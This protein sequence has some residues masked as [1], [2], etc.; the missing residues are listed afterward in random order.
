MNFK[1]L[2][3]L[4][5]L[6]LGITNGAHAV[7]IYDVKNKKQI[8]RAEFLNQLDGVDQIVVGEKHYDS[9]ILNESSSLMLDWQQRKN[10]PLTFAWEFLNVNDQA[11][12]NENFA[13]VKAG[14]LSAFDFI[15]LVFGL[16]ASEVAYVP[17]ITAALDARA[18]LLAV[19]LS[20]AEKASV[21]TGGISAL[22]PLLLPPGFALGSVQYFERFEA[23][24]GGH[25]TP[26]KLA[27]YFAAQCLVD[28]VSAYRLTH[29]VQTP[30]SFL[31]IGEFHSS[32]NDGVME[33]LRI[34]APH[35]KRALI[36]FVA[37][38]S[39][40]YD[41]KYGALADYLFISH[42]LEH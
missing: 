12:V 32:F 1:T 37:D 29:H 31:L 6:F 5:I 22:D 16:G 23:A 15:T 2:S 10:Q 39:E 13:R 21:V 8:T 19:N 36:Q 26:E 33:R 4:F 14:E 42:P 11:R 28:D 34:R 41:V 35:Q 20:R 18:E 27:N 30:L 7:V 24:M 40:S 3:T 9:F 25:T 38:V 17:M